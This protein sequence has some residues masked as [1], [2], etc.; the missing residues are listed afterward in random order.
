MLD[1]LSYVDRRKQ[2]LIERVNKIKAEYG[3]VPRLAILTSHINDGANK[4]YIASKLN[5][6]K[7]IG[8]QCDV[9]YDDQFE[10]ETRFLMEIKSQ[11]DGVIVQ[12][13]FKDFTFEQLQQ[14]VDRVVPSQKDVDGLGSGGLFKPCTPLGIYNYLNYNIFNEQG[15]L[16]NKFK[17]KQGPIHIHVFGYGGLIGQPLVAMLL[18]DRRYTVSM[19]RSK[20]E[21]ATAT[22]LH[23]AADVIVCATPVHNLIDRKLFMSDKVYID[24]GCNLVDGKLL[25]NVSRE[26]YWHENALITPVPNGVGRMTVLSLYENLVDAYD[27]YRMHYTDQEYAKE[28]NHNLDQDVVMSLIRNGK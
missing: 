23:D 1:V 22:R 14:Y 16:Y 21:E 6:A 7:Q 26:L 2:A 4:S 18:S 13:P 12:F 15:D 10:S 5:F 20:T 19:S 8:V 17:N 27:K 28:G 24:C 3:N 11:Y 25:G 9:L